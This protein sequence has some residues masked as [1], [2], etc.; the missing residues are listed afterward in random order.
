MAMIVGKAKG[1]PR[2]DM[3]PMVDLGFLLITFFVMTTTLM[4]QQSIAMQLPDNAILIHSPI[5]E[6]QLLNIH[7]TR[8]A[9]QFYPGKS[10]VAS[11]STTSLD[12]VQLRLVQHKQKV[13]S[14][15]DKNQLDSSRQAVV[16]IKPDSA[17]TVEEIV[18]V[19][20]EVLISGISVYN[21]VD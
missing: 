10:K 19:L 14:L 21:I 4:K 13:K 17:S 3:T 20:D 6:A 1:A 2:I 18:N 9:Y 7:I 11:D 16:I 8:N 15:I 5:K 12:T